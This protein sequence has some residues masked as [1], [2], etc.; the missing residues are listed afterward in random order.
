[1]DAKLADTADAIRRIA[2]SAA[3]L[4]QLARPLGVPSVDDL[5]WHR[6]LV[7]KLVPQLTESPFLV[8]AVV[9][10]TNIGKSLI[11]NHIIGEK[12][13]ESSTTASGTKHPVLVVPEGFSER[14]S[15]E[16]IFRKFRIATWDRADAALE[17][18]DDTLFWRSSAVMPENLIVLDTPDIDSDAR[19]NWDRA[20]RIRR[21]A[22]VLVCVLT[23]QKY[24]DAA[25]R[26]FF[27]K[28]A[29]E[30]QVV[31]VVFNQ[32]ILPDD[33][34]YWPDWL[35]TFCKETGLEPEMVYLAPKDRTAA[36][37]LKLPFYPRSWPA[38]F[39]EKS[40]SRT[41]LGDLSE[42]HFDSIKIRTLR[43]GLTQVTDGVP[44]YLKLVDQRGIVLKNVE[45]RLVAHLDGGRQTG[46]PTLPNGLLQNSVKR[47][48]ASQRTGWVRNVQNVY[49][50]LSDGIDSGV[51]GV[52][53]LMG[54]KPADPWQVYRQKEWAEGVLATIEQLYTALESLQ[55]AGPE[56][57]SKRAADTLR[58][59]DRS[60]LLSAI[61]A[62]YDMLDLQSVLDEVVATE[63]TRFKS[64]KATA[65]QILKKLDTFAAAARP[66]VTA[67]LFLVGA[68]PLV[69]VGV[70]GTALNLAADAAGGTAATVVGEKILGE[71]AG[72]AFSTLQEWFNGLH[73]KFIAVRA[74]WLRDQL[75]RRLLGDLP[76]EIAAAAGVAESEAYRNLRAAREDLRRAL[77]STNE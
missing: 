19:V 47:W 18:A 12:V 23:N 14:H 74:A 62:E 10:G 16:E 15:L 11:F 29:D 25:V 30:G 63:M 40:E 2:A 41:L 64:E 17:A 28:A 49:G 60:V 42:L 61:K 7:D 72:R 39:G 55:E 54:N 56:G 1:M 6:T 73:G 26:Q 51:R 35:G 71:G 77:D 59:I 69:E 65:H 52:R 75:T 58:S 31:L 50:A 21:A 68:G 33:E 8:V 32:V 44:D 13:S 48:W 45:R 5:E 57:V 46:W 66:A 43:G 20:D 53:T 34:P 67:G 22:D 24:N 38:V 76:T 70:A 4:E 36:A 27:R 3:E 9:G 37:E